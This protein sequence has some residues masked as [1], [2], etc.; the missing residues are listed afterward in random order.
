MMMMKS[1]VLL[2]LSCAVMIPRRSLAH[3]KAKSREPSE[4]GVKGCYC[5][6]SDRLVRSSVRFGGPAAATERS[7]PV[8]ARCL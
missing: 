5:N 4:A 6:P 7:H 1:T 2:L 8:H 3:G